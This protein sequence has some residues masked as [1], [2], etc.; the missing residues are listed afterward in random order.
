MLK[1]RVNTAL[2][3]LGVLPAI[4]GVQLLSSMLKT[5]FSDRLGRRKRLFFSE[6]LMSLFLF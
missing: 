1:V 2:A 4:I 6:S 5:L 3:A